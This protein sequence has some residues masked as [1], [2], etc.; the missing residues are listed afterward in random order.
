MF[1]AC[2]H[3][4]V[5]RV[6]T[7]EFASRDP[8]IESARAAAAR[9]VNAGALSRFDISDAEVNA[10]LAAEAAGADHLGRSSLAFDDI[11]RAARSDVHAVWL[12]RA[13]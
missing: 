10:I 6:P 1:R 13:G 7:P 4:Y 11:A 12:L 5:P 9:R 8:W 3:C 2:R